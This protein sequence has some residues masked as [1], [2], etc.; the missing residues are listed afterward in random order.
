MTFS[1]RLQVPAGEEPVTERAEAR[2]RWRVTPEGGVRLP[3]LRREI[4][5]G[6]YFAHEE[7]LEAELSWRPAASSW[8]PL[9]LLARHG[10]SLVLPDHGSLLAELSVGVDQQAVAG[11]SGG[12]VERWLSLGVKALLQA[13]LQF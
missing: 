10:T 7:S 12:A 6:A 1:H 2:L 9:R 11:P 13:R 3:L 4:G 8:H 5:L